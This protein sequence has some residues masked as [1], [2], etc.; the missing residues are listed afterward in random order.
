MDV[1]EF[2]STQ[3]HNRARMVAKFLDLA[4]HDTV[5]EQNDIYWSIKLFEWAKRTPSLRRFVYSGLD[6]GS[7]VHMRRC[8]P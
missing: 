5:G 6:Y 1:M 7:K 4:H 2:S 3:I 8:F